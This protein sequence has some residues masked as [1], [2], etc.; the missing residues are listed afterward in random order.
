MG[1]LAIQLTRKGFLE[2][3]GRVS[4]EN[5]KTQKKGGVRRR[6]ATSAYQVRESLRKKGYKRGGE[7][8]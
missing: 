1:L 4:R 3:K 2:K 5:A 8:T 7:N 6:E